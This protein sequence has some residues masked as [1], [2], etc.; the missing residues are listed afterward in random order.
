MPKATSST[1]KSCKRKATSPPEAP[2]SRNAKLMAD[3]ISK[4]EEVLKEIGQLIL[5]KRDGTSNQTTEVD[6]GIGNEQASEHSTKK[7]VKSVTSDN[8]EG[9]NL[10][11][12]C[13]VH[14][15]LLCKCVKQF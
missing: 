15:Q 13:F 5:Q 8:N 3:A 11:L 12:I 10:R 2:K 9:V 4:D 14:P 6:Q 7:D 1:A